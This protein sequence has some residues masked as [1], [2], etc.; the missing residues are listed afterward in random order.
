MDLAYPRQSCNLNYFEAS[1]VPG[2]CHALR[3][4]AQ[5]IKTV[6]RDSWHLCW[7]VEDQLLTSLREKI[8]IL[9]CFRA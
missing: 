1:F 9:D 6:S 7:W 2:I 8:A 4:V 3:V 5:S